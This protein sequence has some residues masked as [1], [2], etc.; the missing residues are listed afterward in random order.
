M[1]ISINGFITSKCAEEY[2]DCADNYAVNVDNHRFA[3]SDGVSKSFFPKIWSEILVSQFVKQTEIKDKEFIDLCQSEWQ[4]NID[5]IVSSTSTKWFTRTQYNRKDP[6]LAT[7]VGLE[8]FEKEKTWSA[9]AIGDSFL[10]FVPHECTNYE[11]DLVKLSSKPEP[12][13]F[14]NFPDYLS[15]IGDS[16]KGMPV[17]ENSGKLKDGIFYL[18]TD[19]LA[20]WFIND[21]KNA[22][23]NITLWKNQL[24]FE[25]SIEQARESG[26]LTNDDS[27][28]LTIEIS[29]S[30]KEDITYTKGNLTDLKTL[31]SEQEFKKTA[32]NLI[33]EEELKKQEIEL[34]TQKAN[35]SEII[36]DNATESE[37]TAIQNES[38]NSIKEEKPKIGIPNN[39]MFKFAS[40]KGLKRRFKGLA[41]NK[42]K[43]K[44]KEKKSAANSGTSIES[45]SEAINL[46]GEEVV[47][48]KV[49]SIENNELQPEKKG[50]E[51]VATENN[52]EN[53]KVEDIKEE[54]E[55]K[56]P[57]D[58][59]KFDSKTKNI[60]DK[61]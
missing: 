58:Y 4:T 35:E 31:I 44:S 30:V 40:F 9:S 59:P 14:D 41:K 17:K 52:N 28:I 43:P 25:S 51:L 47:T 61:F 45:T 10:F 49:N 1:K 60:F 38:E 3:I 11:K 53:L 50:E 2:I 15:S 42:K 54:V 32:A 29:E 46:A 20:E 19:A 57:K 8:F 5:E 7:F 26:Q 22:I 18:M 23:D 37:L 33:K 24:D 55:K 48:E 21:K 16:H 6:A 13:I 39:G 56:D 34:A 12:I 27:A 36:Q